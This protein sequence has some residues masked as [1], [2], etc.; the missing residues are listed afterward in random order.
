MERS[1]NKDWRNVY[2]T[3]VE[4]CSG[5]GA[6]RDDDSVVCLALC[7]SD[8]VGAF[9]VTMDEMISLNSMAANP[10]YELVACPYPVLNEA[11]MRA[12][13]GAEGEDYTKDTEGNVT[14]TEK[15]TG[16]GDGAIYGL[17]QRTLPTAMYCER[18][19]AV[20]LIY[21]EEQRKAIETWS[22]VTRERSIIRT[23]SMNMTLEEED[24]MAEFGNFWAIQTNA[25][26]GFINGNRD[27][28]DWDTYLT[29]MN[30]AGIQEYIAIEQN[31]WDR[32][33]AS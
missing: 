3:L 20:D 31:A 18:D 2:E 26:K 29:E 33:L 25:L 6:G 21:S 17:Y 4:T 12:S 10:N 22:N 1:W 7:L 23:T 24:V 30:E 9:Y 32:Y 14:F 16:N 8:D 28:T 19:V 13:Y 11:F 15:V 5:A 27:L